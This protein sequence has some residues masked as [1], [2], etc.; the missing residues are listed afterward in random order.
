MNAAISADGRFVAYNSFSTDLVSGFVVGGGVDVRRDVYL[1]DRLTN[2]TTLVSHTPAT[3]TTGGDGVCFSPLISDD[4]RYVYYT[5]RSSNLIAGGQP[6]GGRYIV[7]LYD[8]VS[9][10]NTL[11]THRHDSPIDISWGTVFLADMSGDGRFAV[12]TGFA[13]DVVAGHGIGYG[14]VYLYDRLSNTSSVV[15]HRFDSVS[16]GGNARSDPPGADFLPVISDDGRFI[17][18][19]S[20]ATDLVD[21]FTE[22]G[23]TTDR[24]IFLYDRV[25]ASSTLVSQSHSGVNLGGAGTS[26]AP[27]ISADGRY[28]AFAS[29]APDLIAGFVDGNGAAA[30]DTY[31]YDRVSGTLSLAS[32]SGGAPAAGGDGA[33]KWP[34]I[35]GDGRY[36]AYSSQSTDLIG[37]FTDRNGAAAYDQFVLDRMTGVTVLASGAGGSASVGGNR[38]NSRPLMSVDGRLVAWVSSAT[39]L[40]TGLMDAN[41]QDDIVAFDRPA[42]TATLI[43][44]RGGALSASAGG[45]SSNGRMSDDGRFT[46]FVSIAANLVPGQIDTN[47]S[48]DV[49]VRDRATG[50]TTLVSRSTSGVSTAGNASSG[51]AVI[52]GDGRFVAFNSLATDL[53]PGFVDQ[54]GAYEADAYLF[55]RLSATIT[56]VSHQA[57]DASVGGNEDSGAINFANDYR[58]AISEDGRYLYYTSYATDLVAGFIDTNGLL[59]YGSDLYVFDRLTGTNTLVSRSAGAVTEGGNGKTYDPPSVSADGRYVAFV[60]SSTNL[61]AGY[62]G[63]GGVFLFDRETETTTLVSHAFGLPTTA[64]NG[65]SSSPIVSRDGR[66]IAF[67]STGDN[68][69]GGAAD[70]NFARDIFLHDR[71]TATNTLVSH[72]FSSA[73][74]VANHASTVHAISDEGRF[75]LFSSAA[76]DVVENFIDNNGNDVSGIYSMDVYLFDAVTGGNTLVSQSLTSPAGGGDR[77]H[78]GPQLSGDGRFVVYFSDSKNLIDGFV[79]GNAGSLWDG[80]DVFRYDRLGGRTDLLSRHP[81]SAARSGNSD[82]SW[83]EISRDGS[84]ITFTSAADDLVIGDHNGFADVFNYVTPPPRVQSVRIADGAAQ[85]SVV[86]SLTVTFDQPVF[87]AGDPAAAFVLTGEAGGVQLAAG[88]VSGNRV[89]LTFSGSLTQFGSLV[90]GKYTLRVLADQISNIGPLDGNND[91]VGGDDY[92]FNFHRLFGDADGNGSVDALDFRALRGSFGSPAFV[93]DFDGDGDTDAADFAAFRGRFGSSV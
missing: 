25:T 82:S 40:V 22:G 33:S 85:R 59:P 30:V 3:L 53:I 44:R 2:T 11:V 76:S 75:V 62:A 8:R 17:A 13:P 69:L 39:D 68:L 87:F 57:G 37:G 48:T 86:R 16:T 47:W 73:D 34:A 41:G 51:N 21:G 35:S 72:T 38:G 6:T 52:S 15:S 29:A 4:G 7:F 10:S 20:A 46:V 77:G 49:F 31:V 19:S 84:V 9:G 12:Y 89:T 74:A 32:G 50:M 28:L 1:F 79:D 91:G 23:G 64:A 63:G 36:I 61:I 24:D 14:D 71:L 60:S 70:A 66:F 27:S 54:N 81:T 92:T 93:F 45:A 5:T 83:P 55:D 58:P 42:G 78:L 88:S 65:S 18:Y 90:D 43:S 67:H 56:L 80:L 26:V